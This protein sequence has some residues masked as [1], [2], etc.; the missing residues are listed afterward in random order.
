MPKVTKPV[1]YVNRELLK[2]V[3]VQLVGNTLKEPEPIDV[4]KTAED[5]VEDALSSDEKALLKK[6][7]I[8]G[9]TLMRLHNRVSMC[10]EGSVYTK[11]LNKAQAINTKAQKAFSTLKNKSVE[12]T[13]AKIADPITVKQL[14][15]Q[16]PVVFAAGTK[17][18]LKDWQLN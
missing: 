15:K 16:W 2:R 9:G 18:G 10:N 1:Q 4:Y 12:E 17:H 8:L 3:V 14:E 13:L 5:A 7:P 6:Y 11:A